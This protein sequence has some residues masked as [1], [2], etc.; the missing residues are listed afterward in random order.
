MAEVVIPETPAAE[1]VPAVPPGVETASA[2][3]AGASAMTT[4]AARLL[5]L[6][7]AIVAP[8]TL[9]TALAYY[10]GYRREEA[11]AGYFGID[12]SVVSF[13]TSDYVLRSVDGLFVPILAVLL[14]AFAGVCVRP[15]LPARL[16]QVNSAPPLAAAGIAGLAI[17]VAL[18]AAHP[19]SSS[20]IYLQALG[21]GLGAILLVA[22]LERRRIP[23]RLLMPVRIIGLALV[24]VSLF[25]AT[26]EYA[27]KRGA[28]LAR[29]L[30]SDLNRAPQAAI[31]S[32]AGL[33]IV[34]S[35]YPETCIRTTEN[36]L[37]LYR[38]RYDTFT[39]LLRSGGKY[40]L[41]PTPNHG[42]WDAGPILIL[43]DN[44]NIRLEITRGPDYATTPGDR[45][46][47]GQ[48]PFTC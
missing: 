3:D 22:A 19:P 43:P 7:G 1:V 16:S 18:A 32:K 36:P 41:T 31:F 48:L 10:F 28:D 2:A 38:Y 47:T 15:L 46:A 8:T 25:W 21:P 27:D 9:V 14:V 42:Q 39:L 24:M 30:A 40:F 29:K 17:G 45:T 33:N 26:S 11:F 13:S 5:R 20:Y 35:T 44:D 6:I 34:Q 23:R 12:P 37:A 4:D